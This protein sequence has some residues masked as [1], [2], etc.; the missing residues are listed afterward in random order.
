LKS[1]RSLGDGK[2]IPVIILAVIIAVALVGVII[3]SNNQDPKPDSSPV[4]AEVDNNKTTEQDQQ[5]T[6]NAEQK[7]QRED[8]LNPSNNYNNKRKKKAN[9]PDPQVVIIAPKQ[10]KNL[11]NKREQAKRDAARKRDN[12]SPPE[13]GQTYSGKKSPQVRRAAK[14]ILAKKYPA[15]FKNKPD[16]LAGFV[17]K[18]TDY[19][20]TAKSLNKPRN[21]VQMV[22][23]PEIGLVVL[24]HY[25][26]DGFPSVKRVYPW[27]SQFN[28]R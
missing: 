5:E 25:N 2:L 18:A 13:T 6:G 12:L 9:K 3:F 7:S 10:K 15:N 27:K 4:V 19:P 24:I 23:A 11:K 20:T 14:V 21:I 17:Q 28:N 16:R 1:G 22:V 26:K 8:N